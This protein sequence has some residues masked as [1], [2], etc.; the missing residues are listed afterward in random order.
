M[1]VLEQPDLKNAE[2]CSIRAKLLSKFRGYQRNEGMFEGFPNDVAWA[3]FAISGPELMQVRYIDYSYWNEL[4]GGTRLPSDAAI[5]IRNGAMVFGMST[6]HFLEMAEAL[7][8][9][10][11][12]PELIL[13]GAEPHSVLVVLE[14]HARLTAYALVPDLIPR[15]LT[16]IVG[17]SA[18]ISTWRDFP[19]LDKL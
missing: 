5:R 8:N 7:R 12:Y 10:A 9:G 17:L 2:E 14:G 3:R 16:A 13:V 6:H 4:S 1:S 15:D 11:K 19:P 18:T